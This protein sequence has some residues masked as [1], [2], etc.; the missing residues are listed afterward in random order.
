[1]ATASIFLFPSSGLHGEAKSAFAQAQ[2]WHSDAFRVQVEVAVVGPHQRVTFWF[3]SQS[4]GEVY[5]VTDGQGTPAQGNV[6]GKPIDPGLIDY[7]AAVKAAQDAG[8]MKGD[9]GGGVL[10]YENRNGNQ[11]LT[12]N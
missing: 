3:R 9:P 2:S 11:Q 5:A 8:I 10:S 1:M 6:G 12:W 7:H 4:T